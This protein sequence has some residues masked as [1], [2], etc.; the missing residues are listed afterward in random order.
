M[1]VAWMVAGLVLLAVELHNVAFYALFV[2]IGCLAAALTPCSCPTPSPSRWSPP[3]PCRW[4]GSSS[5]GRASAARMAA[6]ASAT[7]PGV[8]GGFV[9]HEVRH[10]RRRRRCRPQRARRARR[11][12]LARRQRSRPRAPRRDP[13]VIT[14]VQ[15]TTL[16]VWPVDGHLPVD[17]LDGGGARTKDGATVMIAIGAGAIVGLAVAA[18]VVIVLLVALRQ[19]VNIVQQGE[20]GVV[21]RLGE[22]R[23]TH[24]PG[25][26]IIVPFVDSLQRVDIR[27]IPA[28]ATARTSSPRTT[29]SSPSTPRSS[30]RSSRPSRRCSPSPTSTSPSTPSPAPPCAR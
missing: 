22:Y 4:P 30:P 27:E 18:L 11:R 7:A 12:A 13:V 10:A 20:V 2:A 24:E 21:K 6:A 9:G 3:S 17:L 16:I 26:V 14:G 15:G 28:P 25:L 5:C 19:M 29:S 1:V 23:R 8:H